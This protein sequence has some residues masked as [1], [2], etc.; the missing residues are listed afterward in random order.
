V[1]LCLIT[2]RPTHGFAIASLLAK[3]GRLGQACHVPKSVVYRSTA[4]LEQLDLI[5]AAEGQPG[6]LGPARLR[7]AATAKGDQAA[8][9]WLYQPVMHP[10]DIGSELLIKLV[11]LDRIDSDPRELLQLQRAQLEPVADALAAGRYAATGYDHMLALWRHESIS[12]T[13]RF[14]DALLATAPAR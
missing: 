10:H 8:R 13:L 14:L 7:L 6:N 4:R 9:D 1:V 3:D 2:E 5:T 11:L 12:A